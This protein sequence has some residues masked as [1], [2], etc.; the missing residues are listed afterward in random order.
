MSFDKVETALREYLES[1]SPRGIK[2]STPY[3]Y[4]ITHKVQKIMI[5]Q[6]LERKKGVRRHVAKSLGINRNTLLRL[7][8]KFSIDNN[9]KEFYKDS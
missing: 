7:I 5:Q 3:Y 1:L 2:I 8:R 4:D 9:V 6:S